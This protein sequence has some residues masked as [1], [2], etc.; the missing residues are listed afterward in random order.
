MDAWAL[1]EAGLTSLPYATKMSLLR[2]YTNMR[3]I[4]IAYLFDCCPR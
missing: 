1:A 4:A 2:P 3:V